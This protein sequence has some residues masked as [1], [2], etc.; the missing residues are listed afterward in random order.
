MIRFLVKLTTFIWEIDRER[1]ILS[2]GITMSKATDHQ[3][4]HAVKDYW[5]LRIGVF[6][7]MRWEFHFIRRV[8]RVSF[9][10]L[11]IWSYLSTWVCPV[12]N[13]SFLS[14][15]GISN[16]RIVSSQRTGDLPTFQLHTRELR[17]V[18]LNLILTEQS[19]QG[20][21]FMIMTCWI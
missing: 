20:N 9:H 7:G 6:I 15:R 11:E 12:Y 8:G 2:S 17:H 16:W 18:Q 19:L 14:I 21:F 4:S 3:S 1:E 13:N 10:K 5:M